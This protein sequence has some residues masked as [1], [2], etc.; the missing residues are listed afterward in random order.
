MN[1]TQII[2]L[3]TILLPLIGAGVGYLIK[4][5]I[6]K[7]KELNSEL[8][9]QRRE[10]YQ[11]FVNL[12]I[13]LFADTKFNKNASSQNVKELYDFYKKYILFASPNVIKAFSDYFQYLYHL[14]EHTEHKKNLSLITKI[15]Y[16]MRKDI[17]LNNKGL[18]DDG[19]MLM[20]ALITDFDDIFGKK[21]SN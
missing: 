14:D 9:K 18:G 4:S 13:N 16:E 15:M 11:N 6:E 5:K 2:T 19:E 7:E 1:T 3:M 21:D 20:R 8:N 17:G 10:I 12:I